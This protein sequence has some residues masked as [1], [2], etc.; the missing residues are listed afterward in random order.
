MSRTL[1]DEVI[2]EV[3]PSAVDVPG[4]VARQRRNRRLRS[5]VG[6]AGGVVA[7]L[8]AVTLAFGVTGSP[9]QPPLTPSPSPTA[10]VLRYEPSLPS[11]PTYNW[12]GDELDRALRTAAPDAQWILQPAEGA[13]SGADGDAPRFSGSTTDVRTTWGVRVGDVR[14]TIRV[15]F[16]DAHCRQAD[17]QVY[18]CWD[19]L[20]CEKNTCTRGTTPGGLRT[21]I[22]Q[23]TSGPHDHVNRVMVALANGTLVSIGVDNSFQTARDQY[24]WAAHPPLSI[25]AVEQLA[26]LL[27]DR[28]AA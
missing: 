11:F 2:G 6:A 25:G 18:N 3:P 14:G 20:P 22:M 1:F 5:V 10:H 12:L 26:G 24:A 9:P 28:I 27:G 15:E 13:Y 21:V 16:T 19:E 23:Y 7:V 4:I 8:A 17:G